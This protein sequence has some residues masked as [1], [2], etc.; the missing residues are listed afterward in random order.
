MFKVA[1]DNRS[2]LIGRRYASSVLVIASVRWRWE[3]PP[4]R[5]KEY[6]LAC[7]PVTTFEGASRNN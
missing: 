5:D 1:D 4:Y 6:L 3:M 7:L 2:E